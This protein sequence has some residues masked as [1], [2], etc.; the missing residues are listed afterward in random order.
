MGWIFLVY[1]QDKRSLRIFNEKNGIVAEGVDPTLDGK[2]E[3]GQIG[4]DSK[5]KEGNSL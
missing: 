4:V 3:K 2:D 5:E 1:L